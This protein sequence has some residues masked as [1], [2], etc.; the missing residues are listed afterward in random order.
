MDN[1]VL[2]VVSYFSLAGGKSETFAFFQNIFY[3][4]IREGGWLIS[5]IRTMSSKY[6]VFFLRGHP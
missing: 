4:L 2:I 5:Q 3:V 1:I 6:A